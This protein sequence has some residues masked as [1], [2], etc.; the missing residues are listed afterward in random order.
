VV[1]VRGTAVELSAAVG[2][3]LAAVGS[4]CASTQHHATSPTPTSI[5]SPSISATATPAPTAASVTPP[6]TPAGDGNDLRAVTCVS[7]VDCW[8]VGSG[9]SGTLIDH[10]TG[11]AWSVVPSTSHNALLYA[12]TCVGAS[13]CW[14]VGMATFGAGNDVG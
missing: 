2:I 4:G 9:L 5:V 13:D 14:A 10:Y 3:L 1:R 8:A 7:A 12:V 6:P 11:G